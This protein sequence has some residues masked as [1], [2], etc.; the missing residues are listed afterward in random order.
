MNEDREYSTTISMR[1]PISN[2]KEID[3][4]CL[5][6]HIRIPGVDKHY[7]DRTEAIITLSGIGLFIDQNKAKMS[8]PK[9]VD[10]LNQMITNEKYLEW[11]DNLSPMQKSAL[12]DLITISLEGTQRKLAK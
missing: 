2:L 10:E 6:S 12:R 9:F 1:F 3:A 4:R 7:K 11:L 8:D 5:N